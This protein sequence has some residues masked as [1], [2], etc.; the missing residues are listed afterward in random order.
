MEKEEISRQY[1]EVELFK[2]FTGGG[3]TV[4]IEKE[5]GGGKMKHYI[6]TGGVGWDKD[7]DIGVIRVDPGCEEE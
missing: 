4:F 2:L 1:T 7:E 3:I 5:T 6:D